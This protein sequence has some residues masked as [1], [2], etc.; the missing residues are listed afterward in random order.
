[1]PPALWTSLESEIIMKTVIHSLFSL[2]G[3]VVGKFL[4]AV[5]RGW[6]GETELEALQAQQKI[7]PR[8]ARSSHKATQAVAQQQDNHARH[9]SATTKLQQRRFRN[10][11]CQDFALIALLLFP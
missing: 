5:C 8:T 6:R 11:W 10:R 3:G 4:E 2:P 7:A 1:M 9:A